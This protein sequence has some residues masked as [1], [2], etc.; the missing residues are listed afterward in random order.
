MAAG[1]GSGAYGI[2][3]VLIGLVATARV[4]GQ[5]GPDVFVPRPRV[6]SAL[7]ELRRNGPGGLQPG[8]RERFVSLVKQAFGQR[9]KMLRRSLALGDA[10]F[11]AAGIAPDARPEQLS[12]ADW[13]RLSDEASR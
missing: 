10:T 11:E 3:S 5:V 13:I 12:V 6:T 1:P 7:V 2:P 9:R 4:V 8:D